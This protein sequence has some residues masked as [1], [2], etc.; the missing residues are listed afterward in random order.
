MYGEVRPSTKVK[1]VLKNCERDCSSLGSWDHVVIM[2]GANDIT[3]NETK[4]FI[5]L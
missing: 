5:K 3:Q 1:D 2:G 4:N